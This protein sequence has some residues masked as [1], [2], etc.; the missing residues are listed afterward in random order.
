MDFIKVEGLTKVYRD[1]NKGKNNYKI[2]ALDD[3]NFFVEE[4]EFVAIMGKSGC[5]KT[6][7]LRTLGGIDKDIVGSIKFKGKDISKLSMS[8]LALFR[9]REV[10]FVFQEFY[11][12]ESLNVRENI[13]LPMI[14][15]K[16][17]S[18]DMIN[19]TINYA[20]KFGIKERLENYPN[21]LSGGQKQCVAICRALSNNPTLILADEP[22]GNLDS[23][24]SQIVIESLQKL[25]EEMNKTV[26]IVTHDPLIASYCKRIIFMK[27]G[28]NIK[29]LHK[30][31]SRELFFKDILNELVYL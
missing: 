3:V 14:L 29:E 4:R 23:I 28:K 13:M 22:T 9:R 31:N 25:N 1:L 17:N 21:E 5:G 10:G 26:I 12:M 11:L 18:D 19:T 6:T 2:Q 27:D 7:L 20:K 15:D 16:K 30:S 24:S 8:E